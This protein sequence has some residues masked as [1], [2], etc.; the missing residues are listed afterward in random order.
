MKKNKDKCNDDSD[1]TADKETIEGITTEKNMEKTESESDAPDNDSANE[2]SFCD[3]M[4][5]AVMP[6]S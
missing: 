3:G 1:V 2:D 4:P 6:F 5:D